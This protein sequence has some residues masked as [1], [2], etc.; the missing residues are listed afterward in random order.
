MKN[1]VHVFV[2][3]LNLNG[4]PYDFIKSTPLNTK[5]KQIKNMNV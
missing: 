3:V 5:C 1:N 2:R 4:Y